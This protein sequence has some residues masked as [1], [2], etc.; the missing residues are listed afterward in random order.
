[1]LIKELIKVRLSQLI[2]PHHPCCDNT[3]WGLLPLRHHYILL[4][5]LELGRNFSLILKEEM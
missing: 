3:F 4:F 2:P 5:P 1:M